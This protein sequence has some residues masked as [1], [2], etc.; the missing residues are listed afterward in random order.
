MHIPPYW[1]QARLRHETGV[2][3]GA[4]VQRWGWSDTSQLEAE[5]HAQQ[6]AQEALDALLGAGKSQHLG[7]EFERM[8]WRSEYG[9]DGATPIREEILER[10]GDT[11]MTRNSYGAHCLNTERVAIA[12]VDLPHPKAAPS[13]PFKSLILLAIALPWLWFIPLVWSV[14]LMALIAAIA[15]ISLFFSAQLKKW[16]IWRQHAQAED[17]TL[18]ATEQAMVR[19]HETS[20]RYPD[21]G[22]RVYQTP[23]GLRIIVT[24]TAWNHQAAEVQTL[25]RELGV[26]PL[27]AML[28]DKQQ[29]FRARVSAKPW[30]M[31]MSGLSSVERRWPL[32]PEHM[33]ARRQW[34]MV[35]DKKA[36][37]FAACHFLEQLGNQVLSPE[38]QA[39]VPWHDAASQAHSKLPLA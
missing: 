10:R 3:H 5:T 34:S 21:W 27:Y 7:P 8:E 19:V 38:A 16:L 4:T 2:R 17:K 30:R 25:F 26:D 15:G 11:V 13:F 31:G 9:L 23:M 36:E 37:Q 12:D 22:L 14:Q 28:C 29:C 6:R 24:H 33:P 35:Y 39:F 32:S 20:A 1:A 18:S